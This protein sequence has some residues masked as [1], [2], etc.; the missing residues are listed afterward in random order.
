[1]GT[2]S[3]QTSWVACFCGFNSTCCFQSLLSE[4][5]A[6]REDGLCSELGVCL[7]SSGDQL[8]SIEL[9]RFV[10]VSAAFPYVHGRWTPTTFYSLAV[11]SERP[12]SP[13][14]PLATFLTKLHPNF[15]LKA[16][17]F[18]SLE[19]SE[20]IVGSLLILILLCLWLERPK[21]RGEMGIC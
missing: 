7:S 2:P 4:P 11:W 14:P 20:V 17:F 5:W 12:F 19:H 3:A 9:Q 13:S 21:E 8:I 15:Q 18:S 16:Q 6:L 10:P 1:M